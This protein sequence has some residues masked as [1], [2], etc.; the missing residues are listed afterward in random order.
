MTGGHRQPVGEVQDHLLAGQ[1]GEQVDR[2]ADHAEGELQPVELLLGEAH[3]KAARLVEAGAAGRALGL[4]EAVDLVVDLGPRRVP[5]GAAAGGHLDPLERAEDLGRVVGELLLD[6]ERAVGAGD[7]H[8]DRRLGVLADEAAQLAEHPVAVER[9]QVVVVDQDHHPHRLDLGQR[10]RLELR[11]RLG[12]G[13]QRRAFLGLVVG[14]DE[15]LGV[16]LEVGDRALLAVV[17]DA[18]VVP[19]QVGDGRPLLVGDV[20]DD[21]DHGHLELV[22]EGEP[23][24]RPDRVAVVRR[25]VLAE[26]QRPA[27]EQGSEQGAACES[28]HDPPP[29]SSLHGQAPHL[30]RRVSE[31]RPGA[32]SG[33][34]DRP[35]HGRA[36]SP[37]TAGCP[38]RRP[39]R[40][41]L[42]ELV[43][44]Q[45]L[46][47]ASPDGRRAGPQL[48]PGGGVFPVEVARCMLCDRLGWMP[49]VRG[50]ARLS[51]R[52]R[53]DPVETGLFHPASK[54][55]EDS[56]A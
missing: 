4:G 21:V 14:A 52:S 10:R 32:A 42:V 29:A 47:L 20:G 15:L 33:I 40:T 19:G 7:H 51:G 3:G 23:A 54:R 9:L 49:S 22:D 26:H 30:A 37:V 17:E 41:M 25:L 28:S 55:E 35:D 12:R 6:L 36:G 18:E 34:S 39:S 27:G 1:A 53:K 13:R 45:Q 8:L 38:E 2:L 11:P 5:A 46:E 24:D 43:H 31:Q 44:F 48:P 16:E 56:K 50:A